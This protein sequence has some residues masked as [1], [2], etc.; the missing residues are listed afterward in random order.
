MVSDEHSLLEA[1][2]TF[3]P[4]LAVVDLSLAQEGETNVVLELLR[5][6]PDLRLIVLSVHDEA[7]IV[8]RLLAAGA[9]GFVFKRSMATDLAPAIEEVMRGG[10]YVSGRLQGRRADQT[11][12]R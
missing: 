8:D 3:K 9:D 4:D 1:V 6:H 12:Q 5:R 2:A 7:T 10:T 11:I